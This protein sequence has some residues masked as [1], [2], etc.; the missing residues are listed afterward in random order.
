MAKPKFQP[1]GGSILVKPVTADKV[2]SS[3]I[4]LPDTINKEKP[5]KGEIVVLGTGKVN[6]KGEKVAFNVKI[7][8]VVIFKKYSPDDI[9][10]DGEEYLIM[11]EDD[12]LGIVG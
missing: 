9:E 6:D 4:V 11:N 12:I 7:G 2:T 3:G 10:I 1:L 5:Q 8:D